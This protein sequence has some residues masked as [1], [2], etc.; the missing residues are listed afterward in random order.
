MMRYTRQKKSEA[1]FEII[2]DFKWLFQMTQNWILTVSDERFF[3]GRFDKGKSSASDF[4]FF[5]TGEFSWFWFFGFDFVFF[6]SIFF[7]NWFSFVCNFFRS[8]QTIHF[9]QEPAI[10]WHLIYVIV[11][12]LRNRIKREQLMD[13][14]TIIEHAHW[15]WTIFLWHERSLCYVMCSF[16]FRLSFQWKWSV[17]RHHSIL[18]WNLISANILRLHWNIIFDN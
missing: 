10:Y 14:E 5:V 3:F 15:N 17:F 7:F 16:V 11:W 4:R 8:Q 1:E 6:F 12:I 18:H 13:I 9:G 2:F